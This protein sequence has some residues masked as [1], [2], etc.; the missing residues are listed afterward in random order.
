MS[1][2]YSNRISLNDNVNIVNIKNILSNYNLEFSSPDDENDTEICFDSRDD[3]I[4]IYTKILHNYPNLDMVFVSESY[5]TDTYIYI[6]NENGNVISI[7]NSLAMTGIFNNSNE[8]L[9][10]EIYKELVKEIGIMDIKSQDSDELVESIENVIDSID[11][12]I[13]NDNYNDLDI[14]QK[15]LIAN[16][17]KEIVELSKN[18]R[19]ILF[20]LYE[21]VSPEVNYV[22]TNANQE[23]IEYVKS[24]NIGKKIIDIWLYEMDEK[25]KNQFI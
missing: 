10:P 23:L 14:G 1:P 5:E 2:S 9:I 6:Y 11:N 18:E 22:D 7:F 15:Y 8:N 24:N 25:I 3:P 17:M 21:Q 16:I 12:E 19:N 20:K 4:E 13:I